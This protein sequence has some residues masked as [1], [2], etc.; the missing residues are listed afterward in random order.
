MPEVQIQA[1]LPNNS[2]TLIKGF[3]LL[4]FGVLLYIRK[5]WYE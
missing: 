2:V 3:D 5:E 4:C 1:L